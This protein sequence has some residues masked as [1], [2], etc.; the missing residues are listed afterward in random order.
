MFGR[1][2]ERPGE[3]RHETRDRIQGDL[4]SSATGGQ[5]E[6][7]I[8][9]PLEDCP[10][11]TRPRTSRLLLVLV[12]A[13]CVAT[14]SIMLWTM[15]SRGGRDAGGEARQLAAQDSQSISKSGDPSAGVGNGENP[16]NLSEGPVARP[17]QPQLV[18]DVEPTTS[19]P[20]PLQPAV[21][22]VAAVRAEIQALEKESIEIAETLVEEF[23]NRAD[24]LGLLGMVYNR[25]NQTAKAMEYWKKALDRSPNR[26][27]LY[28][29]MAT[30]ALRKGEYEKAV[31]LCGVGLQKGEMLMLHCHL[32]EALNGLGRAEEALKELQIAVKSAPKDPQIY[33]Q[34]GKSYTLLPDHEKAR[35]NYETAVRLKPDHKV[36]YYGLAMACAKLGLEDQYRQA[37]QRHEKLNAADMQAQRGRRDVVYDVATYRT[38]LAI[39]CCDAATVYLRGEMPKTAER[40]LRRAA[41]VAPK[42]TLCRIQLVQLLC[43]K[44]CAAEAVPVAKE[45]VEIE[46][47]NAGFQ[48]RLA[49]IYD[50]LHRSDEARG[51]ANKAVELAPDNEE[52]R[53]FQKQLEVKR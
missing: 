8:R 52:C 47:H 46:P 14:A 10:I 19:P 38:A 42:D 48:L 49:M 34:M 41:E 39:T 35:L 37:M 18:P 3:R 2:R 15:R 13:A 5:G 24:P 32:A 26:P 50:H 27:D 21:D 4:S 1:S 36:A 28:D 25:C 17:P 16:K 43:A 7:A 22:G 20:K 23:P 45:L 30:V 44:N 33:C 40:L 29:A 31:E 12:T 53:S 9:G 51:A 6:A 11:P